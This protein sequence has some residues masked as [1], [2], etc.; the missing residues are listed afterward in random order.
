MFASTVMQ[1]SA[2]VTV[3][4]GFLDNQTAP[5]F[6]PFP[7]RG[8][9]NTAFLGDLGTN[10]K[11]GCIL[12]HNGGGASQTIGSGA[13]VS[14]FNNGA[15][16]QLWDSLIGSGIAIPPGH[17]LILAQTSA[18]NFDT[19]K[20]P[21]IINPALATSGHPVIHITLNGISKSFTDSAQVLNTGGFDVGAALGRNDSMQWRL[22][23]TTGIG[24]PGG[25]GLLKTAVLTYHNDNM[26][27]G[28]NINE[29]VLTSSNVNT[30]SFGKLF[31][32][33]VDGY[34]YAQPLVIPNI[35]IN[36]KV[37]TAVYAATE[38][39]SV[40]AFDA[41]DDIGANANPLWSVNLGP[42][43]PSW[44]VNTEDLVPEIGITSTPVI[45]PSAYLMY[46]V[47]KTM[48]NGSVVQMLHALDTRTG[49]EKL[50]GPV[51]LTAS[52]PGHGDGNDGNG[53][54]PYY[55]L[56]QHQRSALLLLNGVVY[57]ASASHGDNGPY[58]GWV[59]GYSAKT[60][61]QIYI[62]NTT[63]DGG[64][65]GIWQ[66]GCGPASDSTGSIYFST[67]NGTFDADL[68]G[69]DYGDS[70]VKINVK[71]GVLDIRDYFTPF[72]QNDLNNADTDLGSGGA[73]VLPASVGN[74]KTPH[75]LVAAGKE[76]K[77]Y[78]VNRDKM[79]HFHSGD[80]SQIV[81]SLQYAIGGS[82][83]T[84]AYFN[85]S[86]YYGGAGDVLKRFSIS[87]ARIN[88]TPASYSNVGFD[89]TGATPVVT[90]NRSDNGIV[91][92]IQN[93]G[94]SVLHAFDATNLSN[95]LYNSS[96]SPGR[97]D[98]N[99][100]VKFSV[101]TVANGKAY[102]GS[103]YQLSVLGAGYWT[104]IPTISP[105]GAASSSPVIVTISD[106]LPTASIRYT[107]DG[108]KPTNTSALY[109][110]TPLT[111][112]A[113]TLL[114]AKAF[115]PGSRDSGTAS[116]GFLIDGGPGS[117]NGLTGTYFSNIDLTGN[118]HVR[119]DPTVDFD[120][121][122]GSPINGVDGNNWSVRWTG[123]VQPR[124]TGNI[125]FTT[126]TD[127]GVRVWVNNQ[128][129][130]DNWTYHAYTLD[131]GAIN[132]TTGTKYPIQMEF[133]QGY[134]GSLAHLYW[135]NFLQSIAPIPQNQMYSH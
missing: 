132:L 18:F 44:M 28:Q 88:P 77:I 85:G 73:I 57:I 116:A 27:T 31:S 55:P 62:Y 117:G 125:T 78:L 105:N 121:G 21:S 69:R 53:H 94:N 71:S 91:W 64:L 49:A 135:S 42:S 26:R 13:S 17:N 65:G 115:S 54:V 86:I 11:T 37:H 124:V 36:K 4:L 76:G 35:T 80:D 50:G 113:S 34:I 39:N 84:P 30:N 131:N 5:A 74:T 68:G 38:H 102:V 66:G 3:Y 41:D 134:G 93:Q 129:V 2:Q 90:A 72:N 128:L 6:A 75:L 22:V 106:A 9:I 10:F 56:L 119:V 130:I 127:D 103:Q 87:N 25:T 120:W 123:F 70:V 104:P 16:F 98:L 59:L 33:A 46:V 83:D 40:Y 111:I 47:S 82:F 29:S 52:Y 122:G 61:Q 23:G 97:D 114:K 107:T 95:E 14:G 108:S 79:G 96:Q 60:L 109:T 112:A 1:V 58:H 43:I 7:W 32:H 92:A 101:P 8:S 133:F 63:P 19:S 100:Y 89:F 12:I 48:V 24:N 81:Q 99:G 15:I 20:Q 67:G 118:T 45:N 126:A 110:N 51:V